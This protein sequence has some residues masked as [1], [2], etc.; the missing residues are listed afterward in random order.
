MRA[1]LQEPPHSTRRKETQIPNTKETG[2]L[3]LSQQT[4][5]WNHLRWKNQ[6]RHPVKQCDKS[7]GPAPPLF[8]TA[9]PNQMNPPTLHSTKKQ[10]KQKAKAKKEKKQSARAGA[11]QPSTHA[12]ESP[13]ATPTAKPKKACTHPATLCLPWLPVLQL[14]LPTRDASAGKSSLV[15]EPA[16]ENFLCAQVSVVR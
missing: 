7:A 13:T 15:V 5:C 1:F 6:N 2:L 12:N 9:Q 10:K 11:Q 3:L 14:Q 4:V 8:A 16:I